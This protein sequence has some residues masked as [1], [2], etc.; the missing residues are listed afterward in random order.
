MIAA[1]AALVFL[2][3]FGAQSARTKLDDV[4]QA[5]DADEGTVATDSELESQDEQEE[6]VFR[7]GAD[8]RPAGCKRWCTKV[9]VGFPIDLEYVKKQTEAKCQ[10]DD[11][12]N[13]AGG[14]MTIP[15]CREKTVAAKQAEDSAPGTDDTPQCEK[16]PAGPVKACK[17]QD[18]GAAEAL[19][20]THVKTAWC[21]PPSR[22]P[23]DEYRAGSSPLCCD[24]EKEVDTEP[25]AKEVEVVMK[26][27]EDAKQKQDD[28]PA[29]V[30]ICAVGH[31][32]E[33]D[34]F[35]RKGSTVHACRD[36]T[37]GRFAKKVCCDPAAFKLLEDKVK[38][39]E[40]CPLVKKKY[41]KTSIATFEKKRKSKYP[42]MPDSFSCKRMY[43]CCEKGTECFGPVP[44]QSWCEAGKTGLGKNRPA[45][46]HC[47]AVAK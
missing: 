44:N 46:R 8:H 38:A 19:T 6:S 29:P 2:C 5:I 36:T 26:V 24:L 41:C 28:P 32:F 37:T 39:E 12:K 10:D 31:S 1:K 33:V 17:L 15:D 9:A 7:Y 34:S 42:D 27:I 45:L 30:P 16:N 14:G 47:V 11:C 3:M 4:V 21:L 25:T 20:C 23:G 43:M 22:N 18:G 13:C 40:L 35:K